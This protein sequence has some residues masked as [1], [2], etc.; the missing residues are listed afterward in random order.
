MQIWIGFLILLWVVSAAAVSPNTPFTLGQAL[1]RV[2][3]NN[4]QLQAVDFDTRAAAARIRQQSLQTAWQVGIQME[5]LAGSGVGNDLETTLSLGRVMELGNKAA[6]RGDIAQ[7]Q[8]KLLRHEQDAQRLD[9]L[10]ETAQRF[11]DIAYAQARRELLQRQLDSAKHTQR[12]VAQRFRAGKAT[13]AEI[14]RAEIGIARAELMFE[15]TDHLLRNGRSQLAV[16]WGEIEPDFQQVVNNLLQIPEEVAD[17]SDLERL[18]D[19]NPSIVRFATQ[20][21]LAGARLQLARARRQPDIDLSVG[22]RHFSANDDTGLMLNLRAPLGSRSRAAS[23]EDEAQALVKLE[24]LLAQNRK[25]ALRATLFGLHQELVHERDRLKMLSSRIIPA[26][27][28]AVDDTSRSYSNGRYSLL[29]LTQSQDQ[30]LQARMELLDA[31]AGFHRN[32]I[33]IERLIGTVPNTGVNP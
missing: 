17:F 2:L 28:A 25:L 26:A 23:F 19:N 12:A 22:V 1:A 5:N 7:Q 4:P 3:E 32:R 8:A 27:T 33:Q 10:A 31:A 16:L 18:L 6:L 11:S 21:R 15:E 20:E 30:L 13:K 14:K 9:L 24:P 29:E